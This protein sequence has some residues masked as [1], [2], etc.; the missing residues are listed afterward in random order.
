MGFHG[1]VAE[2]GPGAER[3]VVADQ[4]GPAP[5]FQNASALKVWITRLA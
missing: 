4:D 3:G 1:L 5:G 2:A